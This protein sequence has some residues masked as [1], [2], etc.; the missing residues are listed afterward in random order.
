VGSSADFALF[1]VGV[2]RGEGEIVVSHMSTLG[3]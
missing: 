3:S 1:F 2:G